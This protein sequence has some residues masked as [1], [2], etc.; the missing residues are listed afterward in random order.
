MMKRWER[1]GSKRTINHR[2]AGGITK[3]FSCYEFSMFVIVNDWRH[4]LVRTSPIVQNALLADFQS[5]GTLLP[6]AFVCVWRVLDSRT[7]S[8]IDLSVRATIT[9]L[10]LI[11]NGVKQQW[12]ITK[13]LN[14]NRRPISHPSAACWTL[15]RG[16][17]ETC[18][19]ISLI[20]LYWQRWSSYVS[21]RGVSHEAPFHLR[22]TVG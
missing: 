4:F 2:T 17:V 20:L 3:G 13:L 18:V 1:K 8:Q 5:Q 22:N 6:S 16:Q 12:F 10:G 15:N 21:L 14:F 9:S 7:L 11:Y 19:T